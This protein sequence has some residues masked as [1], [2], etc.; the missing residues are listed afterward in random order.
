MI[1][2]KFLACVAV[3]CATFS[4]NADAKLYKWVD[5]SGITHYGETIP[6]EYSGKDTM[7]LE[8]GRIGKRDDKFDKAKDKAALMDPDAERARIE[9]Q[10]H[11]NALINTYASEQEIDLARDRNLQQIEARESSFAT[12][13]KSAN[14]QL[15]DLQQEYEK[16]IQQKRK[17]PKSLEED[18]EEAQSRI[19]KLKIDIE[20]NAKEMDTV[21]ARYAADKARYRELK[22]YVPQE[23]SPSH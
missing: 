21:K 23:K 15:A 8:N 11:D 3:F 10:R 6:P 1:N 12:L 4:M 13:F 14:E 19:A 22:G 20:N 17:I 16:I 9:A 5:N 7:Q 2:S 18:I